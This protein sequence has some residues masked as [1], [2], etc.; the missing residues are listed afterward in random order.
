MS[1]ETFEPQHKP[2]FRCIY[3]GS[4]IAFNKN[5]VRSAE[6]K[7]WHSGAGDKLYVKSF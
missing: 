1:F 6:M 3:E 7:F 5:I 2:V 4:S